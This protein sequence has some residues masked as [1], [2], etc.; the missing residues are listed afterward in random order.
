MRH[1]TA[2]PSRSPLEVV[3]REE[4]NFA[5]VHAGQGVFGDEQGGATEPV[6]E[7]GER[8]VGLVPQI[9]DHRRV[10]QRRLCR[11][12]QERKRTLLSGVELRWFVHER[13]H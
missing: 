5:V 9:G 12:P 6:A 4:V 10:E 7:V 13:R 3:G 11:S 2:C 1:L 8:F